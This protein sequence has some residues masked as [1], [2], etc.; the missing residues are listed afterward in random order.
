[1]IIFLHHEGALRS[2]ATLALQAE[3]YAHI[4]K[5]G[6]KEI[7]YGSLSARPHSSLFQCPGNKREMN[8][9]SGCPMFIRIEHLLSGGFVKDDA[10]YIRIVVYTSDLPRTMPLVLNAVVCMSNSNKISDPLSL[11]KKNNKLE[12]KAWR[13]CN[14]YTLMDY[15]YNLISVLIHCMPC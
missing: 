7:R 4:T 14:S 1:M 10:A 8:I 15:F 2:S 5:P 6:W 9:A 11:A 13:S 12:R 3:G